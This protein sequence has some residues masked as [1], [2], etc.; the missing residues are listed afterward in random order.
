MIENNPSKTIRFKAR[1]MEVSEFLIHQVGHED[2][3]YFSYKM[4]KGQFLLQA[5]KD[6]RK[7]FTFEQTPASP[8]N[9]TCFGFSLMKK[10]LPVSDELSEQPLAFSVLTRCADETQTPKYGV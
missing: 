8:T 10:F 5:M 3:Q 7:D 9:R 2:I 1:D 4:R 6:K